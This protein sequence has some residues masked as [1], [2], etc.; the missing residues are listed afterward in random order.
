MQKVKREIIDLYSDIKYGNVE[1]EAR[2]GNS[3]IS[4][5]NLIRIL[6]KEGECDELLVGKFMYYFIMNIKSGNVHFHTI[7]DTLYLCIYGKLFLLTI[8]EDVK[9][10]KISLLRNG[11]K[12]Y[13]L[14]YK[15][16]ENDIF[17][18]EEVEEIT[19]AEIEKLLG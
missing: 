15:F 17:V 8:N 5:S 6:S 4:N 18:D 19:V 10:H 12:Y 2:V 13:D 11:I 7:K 1:I 14:Y 3:I 16:S 9:L